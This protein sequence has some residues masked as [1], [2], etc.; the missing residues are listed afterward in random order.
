[1]TDKQAID[2]LQPAAHEA[3]FRHKTRRTASGSMVYAKD[4]RSRSGSYLKAGYEVVQ[5]PV[6]PPAE[7][8]KVD[9]SGKSQSGKTEGAPEIN[10]STAAR[11]LAEEAG[12]D[13]TTVTGTGADGNITKP[14]VQNAI[15]AL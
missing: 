4:A 13:L 10:A 3:V 15:D 12:I 2:T 1:M 5:S 14:D 8:K 9:G 6:A 7:A 11:T